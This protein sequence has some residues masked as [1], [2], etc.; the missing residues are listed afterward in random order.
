[1]EQLV[2]NFT[3]QFEFKAA[4]DRR[5]EGDGRYGQHGAEMRFYLKGEEGAVQFILFTGWYAGIIN[6]P[7][8]GWNALFVKNGQMSEPLPADLGYHSPRQMYEGQSPMDTCHILPEG[9]CYYDG[10]GLNANRI[11]S[12][13]MHEGE[14]AMWKALE[15]YYAETFKTAPE[16]VN[17][18]QR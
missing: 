13:L 6:K 17:E 16:E 12:I 11:F 2:N 1:M 9:K 10:S 7:D 14:E 4:W 3:R 18:Q 5:N 8:A 15:D